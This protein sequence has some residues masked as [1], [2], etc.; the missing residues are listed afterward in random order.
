MKFPFPSLLL[1]V[2]S[3]AIDISHVRLDIRKPINIQTKNT[4]IGRT[5]QHSPY[6]NI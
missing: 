1:S 2:K 4:N 6:Y 5:N 3:D